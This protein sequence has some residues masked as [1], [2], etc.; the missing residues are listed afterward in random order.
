MPTSHIKY[1][2]QNTADLFNWVDPGFV[3]H[4]AS[5]HPWWVIARSIYKCISQK[6]FFTF[7]KNA[8]NI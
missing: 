2:T 3:F 7:Q 1:G 5:H 8:T 4:W 6:I